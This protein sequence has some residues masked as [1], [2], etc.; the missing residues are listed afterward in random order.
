MDMVV[1][2]RYGE[3]GNIFWILG[4]AVPILNNNGR[5]ADA[6]TMCNRVYNCDSYEDALKVI[7]E[8][9]ELLEVTDA[10]V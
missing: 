6:Q 7:G 5:M 2:D 10:Q 1:F 9:V 8:Y 3:S 4:M